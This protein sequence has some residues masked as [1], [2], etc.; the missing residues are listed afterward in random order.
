MPSL[1]HGVIQ[2]L[3]NEALM[4]YHPRYTIVSELTLDLEGLRVTPDL[5]VYPQIDI[6]L[7]QDV[8]RMTEPP[9]IAVEIASP[10]QSQQELVDK[11]RQ[12]LQAGVNTCWLVQPAIRAVT[13]FSSDMT[14]ET[15]TR[16]TITDPATDIAVTLEDIFPS[17]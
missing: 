8:I 14:S 4:A 1:N 9:L 2:S 12:M 7:M 16:G 13:V 15:F 10:S 5:C 11:I 6:D 17:P 3:L